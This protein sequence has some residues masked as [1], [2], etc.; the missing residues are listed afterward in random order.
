V[1]NGPESPLSLLFTTAVVVLLVTGFAAVVV[2]QLVRR[3]ARRRI[4]SARVT[5]MGTAVGR[6]LHQIQNPLQTL[7]LQSDRLSGQLGPE[8]T[9]AVRESSSAILEESER[10]SEF[11]GELRLYASGATRSPTLV[12]LDLGELVSGVMARR[13]RVAGEAV[14]VEL[15]SEEEIRVRADAYLL[16]Q[17]VENLVKNA[18]E[19][20]DEEGGG[21]GG[22]VRVAREGS[23]A[24]VEVDDDGPGL[25]MDRWEE[26]FEPFVTSKSKGM[27]LGLPICR[28]IARAHGGT[29]HAGR[30][31]AGGGRF[32]LRIPLS[33][34]F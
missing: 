19:A 15:T 32:T 24:A 22:G 3:D 12:P 23:W 13:N 28:D 25:P 9:P 11:L 27:G 20:V 2:V 18:Q 4:Q 33:G 14:P 34:A 21:G 10:V 31:P 1:V 17:A 26:V 29:L 16:D 6:I 5:A 8:T 7:L 30:S